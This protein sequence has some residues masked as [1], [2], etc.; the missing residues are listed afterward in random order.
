[1]LSNDLMLLNI[2]YMINLVS[3][4]EKLDFPLGFLQPGLA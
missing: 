1:M 2:M 3:G 4:V